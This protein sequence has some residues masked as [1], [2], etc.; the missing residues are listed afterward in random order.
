M[1][2]LENLFDYGI[3]KKIIIII[4]EFWKFGKFWKMVVLENYSKMEFRKIKFKNWNF[5]KLFLQWNFGKFKNWS[6]EKLFE[7]WS[8]N[9]IIWKSGIL[10]IIL[11][12]NLWKRVSIKDQKG[13]WAFMLQEWPTKGMWCRLPQQQSFFCSH[14]HVPTL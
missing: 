13:I 5:G 12:N 7:N 9:K 2:F 6:F 14:F 11:K 1:E 10:K 3:F 4:L 8:E